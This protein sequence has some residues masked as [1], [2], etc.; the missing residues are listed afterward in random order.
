[1][2]AIFLLGLAMLCPAE[3]ITLMNGETLHEAR[4]LRQDGESV[5]L[6]HRAGVMR[7]TFDRLTPELQQRFGLTPAEV[8][9]RREKTRQA[10]KEKALA[11]EKKLAQQREAL[12]A[13]NLSPRYVTG[14]E[15]ASLYGACGNISA[16]MAQYLAADWNQREALRC[17]LTVEAERYKRDAAKLL[18]QVEQERSR[19][20]Q[21]QEQQATLEARLQ[22][23][24]EQL[25]QAQNTIK[26]LEEQAKQQP[27]QSTTTVVTSQPTIV[28]IYRPTPI[29]VPPIQ[30]PVPPA[31]P[32]PPPVKPAPTVRPYQPMRP[33]ILPHR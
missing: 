14:T 17:G 3:D 2:L 31:R 20:R 25:K 32:T 10:E 22:Q 8:E 5:T 7:V 24:Q 1:M 21:A 33:A 19:A 4:V 27:T 15:L 28:P 11:K 9:A 16:P 18:P 6:S 12:A 30:R 29:V 13:S 26:K 23:T